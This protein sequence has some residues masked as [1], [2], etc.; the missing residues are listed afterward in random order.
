MIL[1]AL[2]IL[3]MPA[4]HGK[5][6]M[7]LSDYMRRTQ[8]N[9]RVEKEEIDLKIVLRRMKLLMGKGKTASKLD[10]KD[11]NQKND[12]VIHIKSL[13]ITHSLRLT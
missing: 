10:M 6:C 3:C 8:C 12:V 13:C 9:G 7:K 4:Q 1:V 5:I 11:E 2:V